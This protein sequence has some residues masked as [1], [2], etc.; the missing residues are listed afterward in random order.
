MKKLKARH[1]ALASS[2][3]PERTEDAISYKSDAQH[4]AGENG[5]P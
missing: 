2:R 5:V 3:V 4:S 1:I